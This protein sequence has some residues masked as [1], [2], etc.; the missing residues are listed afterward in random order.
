MRIQV[1]GRLLPFALLLSVLLAGC[2]PLEELPTIEELLPPNYEEKPAPPDIFKELTENFG[3]DLAW[4][5]CFDCEYDWDGL[6]RYLAGKLP[7][8]SYTDNTDAYIRYVTSD[9]PLEKEEA[10]K[11]FKMFSSPS[12]TAHVIVINVA[13]IRSI[14]SSFANTS[15]DHLVLVGYDHSPELGAGS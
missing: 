15:G 5:R 7:A 1:I 4:M 10:R 8:Y 9:S 6:N 2:T 3:R 13:Y 12:K 11:L 14:D